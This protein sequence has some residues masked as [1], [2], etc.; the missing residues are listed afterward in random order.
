MLVYSRLSFTYNFSHQNPTRATNH[1]LQAKC[2]EDQH[3]I[4]ER[5]LLLD[6]DITNEKLLNQLL[7]VH[8]PPIVSIMKQ[9]MDP[10][11][12]RD[13]TVEQCLNRLPM[14]SLRVSTYPA[15]DTQTIDSASRST[16]TFSCP[17][18]TDFLIL[19]LVLLAAK[20]VPSSI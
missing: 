2:E 16:C 4:K 14:C 15:E 1:W 9:M 8:G 7:D 3:K 19:I 18:V 5:S 11:P 6:A 13:E 20:K 10:K 17:L 12:Y